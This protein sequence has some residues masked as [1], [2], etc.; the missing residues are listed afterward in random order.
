MVIEYGSEQLPRATVG[1]KLYVCVFVLLTTAGLQVPIIGEGEFVEVD[2]NI[3]TGP[4]KQTK[5]GKLNVG[6]SLGFTFTKTATCKAHSP[7]FGVKLIC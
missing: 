2:G 5:F 3:G 6:I 4:F 7:G 1:V